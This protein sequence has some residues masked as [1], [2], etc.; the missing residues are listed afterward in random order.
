MKKLSIPR[1]LYGPHSTRGAGVG[2]LKRLGFTSEEVAEIGKWKSIDAFRAHYLRLGAI[3]SSETRI[4]NLVHTVSPESCAEPER[5]W[6][7]RTEQ[8][9]GGSDREGGA[10]DVGETSFYS[11]AII[12]LM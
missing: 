1:E 12:V 6:T 3:K 11:P 4:R 10:Q 5:S 2:M 7:P 8:D 9:V